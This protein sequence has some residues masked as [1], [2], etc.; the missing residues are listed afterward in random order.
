LL[1][2][3]RGLLSET[4]LFLLLTIYAI[5]ASSQA[6]HFAMADTVAGLG[7]AVTSGEL[8]SIEELGIEEQGV[9]KQDSQAADIGSAAEI[10]SHSASAAIS[11]RVI[12]QANFA[13]WTPF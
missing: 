6:A 11:P 1:K 5:R 2:A 12:S 4:P 3:C 13:R 10:S 8:A 7:G 9:E